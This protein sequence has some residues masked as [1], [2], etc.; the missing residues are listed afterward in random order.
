[1]GRHAPGVEVE[2]VQH[3]Q[4]ALRQLLRPQLRRHLRGRCWGFVVV[5]LGFEVCNAG[6]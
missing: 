5:M 1:M 3:L 6:V 2:A 4:L